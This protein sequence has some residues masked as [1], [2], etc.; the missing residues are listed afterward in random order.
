GPTRTL[1]KL[2]WRG[3]N[4]RDPGFIDFVSL[5]SQLERSRWPRKRKPISMSKASCKT[6][7]ICLIL[8]RILISGTFLET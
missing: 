3:S 6:L 1:G 7:L 2:G 4:I 5:K 8:D